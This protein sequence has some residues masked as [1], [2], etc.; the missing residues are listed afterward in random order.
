MRPTAR[1]ATGTTI[2]IATF[3]SLFMAPFFG[4]I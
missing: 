2:P 3:E 4:L 1:I